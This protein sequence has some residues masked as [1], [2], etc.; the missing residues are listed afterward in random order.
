MSDCEIQTLLT[1]DDY[2]RLTIV[3]ASR[4]CFYDAHSSQFGDLFLPELP[5]PYP[6]LVL[7]H[8]GC[9]Q[10]EYGLEPLGQLARAIADRGVAV[11]SIEYRRLGDGGGWPVTFLDVAAATDFLRALASQHA[12]DLHRVATAGHSAGGQLALWLAARSKLAA[13]SPLFT[14]DPL[15]VR[16]VL[17]IA[18]IPDLVAAV[19]RTVCDDAI[20][21][22]MGGAP[23][24]VAARYASASPAAL[25]PLGISHMHIHGR[26]DDIVPVDLVEAYV[27]SATQLG[28]RATLAVLPQ[29]GHFEPVDAR[30]AAGR[31]VIDAA[32]GMFPFTRP[33]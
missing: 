23:D 3:P 13:A 30:S 17:S 25:T 27:A 12:L 11:W 14:A 8:G 29:A 19:E 6:V 10:A 4:R 7:I 24:E 33:G 1:V 5:G 28:D 2:R 31:Q 16:G 21:H 32:V 15:P 18:G 9:W 26:D 20:L 22:L